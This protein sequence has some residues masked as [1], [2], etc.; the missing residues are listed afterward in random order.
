MREQAR[1]RRISARVEGE[2]GRVWRAEM[3]VRTRVESE[4]EG[5]GEH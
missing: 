4:G 1:R 5:K 3:R 2:G